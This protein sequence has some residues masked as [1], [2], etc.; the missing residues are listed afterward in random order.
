MSPPAD[1]RSRYSLR[2]R[3][4][5]AFGVLLVLFLGLTGTVLDRAFKQSVRAAVEERLQLQIYAL[6][7]VAEPDGS[8]FFVPDLEDPRFAQIDSGLYGLIFDSGGNE[9]WRSG[10]ALNLLLQPGLLNGVPLPAGQTRFGQIESESLGPMSYAMYA[11]LWAERGVEYRF[12]VFESTAPSAAEIREF[13]SN[14]WLWLGGLTA[15]LSV[16]QYL[17]LRWGMSPLKALASEVSGIESGM[18]DTLQGHY[19]SELQTLSDNLNLLIRSERERQRRYRL[20]LDD[21]AHSLKTPLA[22]ISGIVQ[23]QQRSAEAVSEIHE[24]VERMNQIVGYQLKRAVKSQSNPMVVREISVNVVL[25]KLLNALAKVYRDKHMQVKRH[26]PDG[27]GFRGEESDLMELCGNLLDN[28]FKYG[29]TRIRVRAGRDESGLHLEI[30]DDGAGISIDQQQH[31][32]ERGAR[33]DTA[34]SVS[35]QGIGLAVALDIVS[36]YGGKLQVGNNPEGGACI[37]VNLP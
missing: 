26:V 29:S 24:Q 3:M 8:G 31:V 36:S 33:A 27:L 23:D 1:T 2:T 34:S 4:A 32:L 5:L 15:L 20:T 18:A 25:D 12:M 13:Q 28:A 9:M 6:L 10:S 7:G 30:N 37:R 11:I 17:L 35:G 19:P 22:V 16:I 14:L 21:L